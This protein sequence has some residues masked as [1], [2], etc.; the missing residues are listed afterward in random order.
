MSKTQVAKAPK[1]VE[2]PIVLT[3]M[4]LLRKDLD[5]QINGML[6]NHRQRTNNIA[7]ALFEEV[8]KLRAKIEEN[9]IEFGK[10]L[11]SAM[12]TITEYEK[13]IEE[14]KSPVNEVVTD[15]SVEQELKVFTC[16]EAAVVE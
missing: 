16:G 15:D 9:N 11:N 8:V 3:N 1:T 13:Q 10:E 5:E 14:L 7:N 4:D 6:W 12:I 2:K